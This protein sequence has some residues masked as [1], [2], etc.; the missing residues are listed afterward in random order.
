MQRNVEEI[1]ILFFFQHID[2]NN[3]KLYI[4]LIIIEINRI[5]VAFSTG[6]WQI[7]RPKLHVP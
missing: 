1:R 5:I 7:K 2:G 3:F 6:Y 4:E